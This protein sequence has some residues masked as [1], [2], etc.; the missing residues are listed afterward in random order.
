[1]TILQ[2]VLLLILPRFWEQTGVW[3]SMSLAQILTAILALVLKLR[4]DNGFDSTLKI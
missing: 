4:T 2:V 3:W 1:M